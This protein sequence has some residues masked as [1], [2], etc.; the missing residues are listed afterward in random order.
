MSYG[1]LVSYYLL[2]YLTESLIYAE[3]FL[4]GGNTAVLWKCD[5]IFVLDF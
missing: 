2:V 5:S 3:V 1:T 4:L